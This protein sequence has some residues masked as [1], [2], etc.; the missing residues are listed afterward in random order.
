MK[1]DVHTFGH[2]PRAEIEMGKV[3]AAKLGAEQIILAR[4]S[5]QRHA[6]QDFACSASVEGRSIN[7]PHAALQCHFHAGQRLIQ[8][9]RAKLTSERRCAEAQDR[10]FKTGL[11][12]NTGWDV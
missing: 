4:N 1:T 8:L 11:A 9:Y 12:Q 6:Q 5:L 2:A 7:E 3:V 10:K